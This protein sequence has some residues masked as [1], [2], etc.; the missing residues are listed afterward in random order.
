MV[1]SNNPVTVLYISEYIFNKTVLSPS[2]CM[3]IISHDPMRVCV[4]CVCV[5][6]LIQTFAN[7]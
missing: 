6:L 2:S 7:G 3:Y 1:F 5:Y 4:W